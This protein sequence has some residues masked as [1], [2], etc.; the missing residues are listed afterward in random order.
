MSRG[1]PEGDYGQRTP[2]SWSG[3]PGPSDNDR[4]DV[5]EL[6]GAEDHGAGDYSPG[7]YGSDPYAFDAGK[8]GVGRPSPDSWAPEQDYAGSWAANDELGD[9]SAPGDGRWAPSGPASSGP[10]SSGPASSGPAL[11][12]PALPGPAP[13][14]PPER[15]AR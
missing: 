8:Y 7:D 14:V 5:D 12:G 11:P 13:A 3:N 15:G 6:Y 2:D 10:A 1:R 9:P 4:W